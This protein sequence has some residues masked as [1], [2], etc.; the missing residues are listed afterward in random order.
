MVPRVDARNCW[1]RREANNQTVDAGSTPQ[2]LLRPCIL[3]RLELSLLGLRL[4]L[5]G[6]CSWASKPTNA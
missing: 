1:S 2:Y 3:L 5:F 4:E 6:A